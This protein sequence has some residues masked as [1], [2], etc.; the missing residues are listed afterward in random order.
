[1]A[2]AVAQDGET[3][4]REHDTGLGGH[5]I[6]NMVS[7]AYEALKLLEEVISGR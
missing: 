6:G 4:S 5:G 7:F 1:V 3:I 2:L